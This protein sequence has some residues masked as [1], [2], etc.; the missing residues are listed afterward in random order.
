MGERYQNPDQSA[1]LREERADIAAETWQVLAAEVR[2]VDGWHLR[3]H[4]EIHY[5]LRWGDDWLL[6]IYPS[7]RRLYADRNHHGPFIKVP[8]N[9]DLQDVIDACRNRMQA[10]AGASREKDA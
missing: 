6:H 4:S 10:R 1:E 3:K 8:E 5:S 9:W 7:N 2:D